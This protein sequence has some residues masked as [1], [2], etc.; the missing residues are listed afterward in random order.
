MKKAITF[1]KVVAFAFLREMNLFTQVPFQEANKMVD[2]DSELIF[3]GS[4][5]SEE[6]GNWLDN[7]KFRCLLNPFGI[8]YNPVSIAR[9][10]RSCFEQNSLDKD[11][12]QE[13]D[14]VYFHP[15]YHSSFNTSS[16]ERFV[17]K[18]D[19]VSK[20]LSAHLKSADFLFLTFGTAI[21]FEWKKTKRVV[22]NCHR[23]PSGDFDKR[24]LSEEEMNEDLAASLKK[25]LEH[26]PEIQ[27]VLTVSPIRHLR[28]GAIQNLRSK[29]RLIRLCE[30]LEAQFDNCSYLP[31][32]EL[33]MDELRDYRFY[34]Q[35]DLIHLNDGGLEVIKDRFATSM[36][37]SA[38]FATIRKVEKWR[39]SM[40]HRIQNKDSAA[41]A[42]FEAQL[43]EMTLELNEL[44]PGRFSEELAR[45]K[46]S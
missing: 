29:A 26:N 6:I 32:Y 39:K 16:R 34:R 44:L 23:L 19:T 46:S 3:I 38:C 2:Y 31:I 45:F 42:K 1:P 12:I 7:L 9:Q 35:D 40:A 17:K 10:L 13:R 20:N 30:K 43:K 11:L 41:A 5:F 33:V 18:S 28:H 36:I 8:S 4:C 15:D 22:N 14:G 25:V 37:D 27:I 21:A 24:M